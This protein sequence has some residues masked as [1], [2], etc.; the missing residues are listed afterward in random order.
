MT[1]HVELEDGTVLIVTDGRVVAA[2]LS[3]EDADGNPVRV[4]IH[5]IRVIRQADA[6]EVDE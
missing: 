5:D 6:D 1:I 4:P 3:Y 2:G